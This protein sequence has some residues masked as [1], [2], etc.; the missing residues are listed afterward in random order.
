MNYY[1]ILGLSNNATNDEIK[2]AY[3]TL[4]KK[5]HP[6]V[7]D[8]AN[9]AAFFRLIQEAYDTLSKENSRLTYDNSLKYQSSNSNFSYEHENYS[10]SENVAY[11]YKNYNT[12]ENE[13]TYEPKTMSRKRKILFCLLKLLL[14]PLLPVLAFI[15]HCLFLISNI[16]KKLCHFMLA[17]MVICI[18]VS[19]MFGSSFCNSKSD[20]ITTIVG[21][22]LFF[23]LPYIILALPTGLTILAEKIEDFIFDN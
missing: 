3:R 4:C 15:N 11:D 22:F 14:T 17:L 2:T 12:A 9:A 16:I 8:A 19:P 23:I 7:N 6:D 5:Y 13:Y 20:W 10:T 1:E 21:G 18:I